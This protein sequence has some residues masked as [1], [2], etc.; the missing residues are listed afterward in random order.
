MGIGNRRSSRCFWRFPIPNSPFPAPTSW[1]L[2][3]AGEGVLV[4]AI[5]ATSHW[6]F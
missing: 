4:P 6:Q 5:P 1:Q 3:V 2:E